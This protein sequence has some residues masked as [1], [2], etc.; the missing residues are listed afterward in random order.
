[1]ANPSSSSR[2][3]KS[4]RELEITGKTVFM[5]LDFNVP[6][7]NPDGSD[8]EGNTRRVE[9]DNRIVESLPTIKYAIE[10]GARL[11][12]AS[13]L[14]RP[15]GK[16]NPEFSMEPV[17]SRLANLLGIE[18][19]LA[20]DCVGEGIELMAAGLKNGQV[21][22]L[23]NLRFHEGEEKN[24][25]E[26]AHQLARLGQVYINDAFG[27][28]HRKHASTYGVAQLM[29]YRGMGFLIE[30]ELKF[31][32]P[33]LHNPSKPFYAILGGSKVTDK[34]KTIES[35]MRKVDG[36]LIGGA[37]AHAFW[38][39]QGDTVPAGAKQPKPADVEAARGILKEA[40]R[41]ELPV[42]VPSDT[43]Q[44]FDI[45]PKTVQKF[46]ETLSKA[47]TIFWNGPLGWFEKPDYAVGTFE[48]AR[49]VAKLKAVKIVGGGDTVS[50]IKQS[51]VSEHF[52][53][54]STGGGAVL[55]YLEGNGLPGI[56][57]LK[58][59]GREQAIF[60]SRFG[61]APEDPNALKVVK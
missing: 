53:H 58:L 46:I 30:K 55:E 60:D 51:G 48:V 27:T 24:D 44:G 5:R 52:D 29:Q 10:K 35:L 16:V 13:H 57:I 28:A 3:I 37:M 49:A 42:I 15:D 20:D 18:V 43:N 41:R 19:T 36:L 45:G 54:L 59:S 23:E 14:G 39:A 25:P 40:K 2:P 7:S 12:L 17:A 8:A 1:M 50:A 6:L 56:D 31:L 21:M 26:F 32:D 22:M 61:E 34:L 33:L 11:V 47:K 38:A 9:D 4:I